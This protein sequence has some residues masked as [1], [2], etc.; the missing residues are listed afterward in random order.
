MAENWAHLHFKF[1]LMLHENCTPLLNQAIFQVCYYVR[2]V[3]GAVS[4]LL[5][6][7][8]KVLMCTHCPE[9]IDHTGHSY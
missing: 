3:P 8:L 1:L 2:I 7:L 6:L 4:K 9:I 5:Q